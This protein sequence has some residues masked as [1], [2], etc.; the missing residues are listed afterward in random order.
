M[1]IAAGLPPNRWDEFIITVNYLWMFVLTKSLNNITPFEAYHHH[2]PNIPHLH[3]IGCQAFILILNKH[4]AKVFQWSEEFVL[5]SYRS[6]SKTYHHCATH[7]DEQEVPFPPGV[8][9][10]LDDNEPPPTTPNLPSVPLSQPTTTPLP[11]ITT[12]PTPAPVLH[13]VPP[14]CCTTHI[15]IASSWSAESSESAKIS[16][17][18]CVTLKSIASKTWLHEQKHGCQSHTTSQASQP[19]SITTQPMSSSTETALQAV[20]DLSDSQATSIMEQLYRDGFEWGLQSN[21]DVL[22]LEEPC[23]LEEA[24]T[25]PDA[26]KWLAACKDKLTSICDLGVFQ[27]VPKSTANGHTIMDGKFVFKLKCDEHG[28]VIWWKAYFMVKGYATIYGINYL[29]TTTPTMWIEAFRAITHVT[30]VRGWELHQVDIVT[31]FLHGKLEPGEEVYTR[32]P[33][34]FWGW[35]NAGPYLGAA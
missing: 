8:T 35:R 28:K 15:P 10:G 23:T 6:N 7:K 26:P 9:Q 29:D 30:A 32:Q 21:A 1:R 27:L 22:S 2:K 11:T 18:Q 3:E 4:N 24:L 16:T 25:S 31:A 17:V 19:S 14:P 13:S 12:T 20:D 33:K 5:I 34:G